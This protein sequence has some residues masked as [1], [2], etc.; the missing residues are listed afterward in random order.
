MSDGVDSGVKRAVTYGSLTMVA[1]CFANGLQN[2]EFQSFSQA[3][4]SLKH[5]FHVSDFTLGTVS[6]STGLGGAIG[7]IPIALLCARYARTRVLA[8]MFAAWALLMGLQGL[9]PTFAIFFFLRVLMSVTE[10]TDPAALPLISDYWPVEQRASKVGIFNAGASVGAFFGIISAGVLV[11]RFGWRWGLLV[12]VPIGIVG[13]LLMWSRREPPRGEQDAA[14]RE[15]LAALSPEAAVLEEAD[16]NLVTALIEERVD[17]DAL[18][19]MPGIIDP[20]TTTKWEVVKQIFRLRSWR[21]VAFGV[22]LTQIMQNGVLGDAVLQAHVRPERHP[23]RGPC[24]DRGQRRVH[25]DPRRRVRRRPSPEAW[26]PAS[27]CLGERHRLRRRGRRLRPR[28]QHAV[29]AGRRTV[30]VPRHDPRRR[31]NRSAVRAAHGR[32]AVVA[33]SPGGVGDQ[34]RAARVG[35]RLRRGRRALVV[36]RREPA[37]GAAVR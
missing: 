22:G 26:R 29:A 13:A 16:E 19:E 24:A 17:L 35:A 34:H 32:H 36:V 18:E 8:C 33:P 37:A 10:A 14:F 2:G 9:A 21:V 20:T 30:P 11:D 6:F 31:H 23:G 5:A 12:W 25:R 4:E 28:V 27:A 15:T 1:L 7:S 3:T